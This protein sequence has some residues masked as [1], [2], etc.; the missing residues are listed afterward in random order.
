MARTVRF[1][2][3]FT[4]SQIHESKGADVWQLLQVMQSMISDGQI[5]LKEAINEIQP[6]VTH[7][8]INDGQVDI[9]DIRDLI[10]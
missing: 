10:N 2:I 5:N 4:N 1:I 9:D 7:V 3:T 6:L 8:G